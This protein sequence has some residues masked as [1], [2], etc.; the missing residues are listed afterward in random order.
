MVRYYHEL[1]TDAAEGTLT[2][3]LRNSDT[4]F[5]TTG[6]ANANVTTQ[7]S[8][9]FKIKA[10]YAFDLTPPAAAKCPAN[11]VPVNLNG[12]VFCKF[13]PVGAYL[14]AST[15]DCATCL[16][17]TYQFNL[18]STSCDTCPAGAY[19][20]KGVL[21][22]CPPGYY[23]KAGATKCNECPANTYASVGTAAT[24]CTPCP[25]FT[26]APKASVACSVPSLK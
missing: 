15:G 9:T 4:I 25:K 17:G 16:G 11:A 3:A 21:N 22:Y 8:V 26:V 6:T 14:K 10:G 1:L 23:S 2:V 12:R 20:S 5:K 18:G 7:C 24:S 19:C 13:C